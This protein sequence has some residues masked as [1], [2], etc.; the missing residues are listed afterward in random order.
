MNAVIDPENKV[1]SALRAIAGRWRNRPDGE[2]EMVINRLVI[3]P[4]I[5]L[6]LAVAALFDMPGIEPMHFL[7]ISIYVAASIAIAVDLVCRPG[8]SVVRRSLAMALDL[9]TLSYGLHVGD[10]T[11]A[12]LYPIYLWTIFGNGFRF[13]LPYL[14]AATSI[15][16]VG[17]ALVI[18]ATE[19]WYSNLPLAIGLLLGLVVLP[20]Y[21]STLIRKLSAAKRQA[22]EASRAKSQFLASVSHELRTPLNAVIGMSEL[23]RDSDLDREQQDMAGTISGSARSLLSL[24]EGILDFS[25]IEAGR[26][27]IQEIEF[28][29]YAQLSKVRAML[30]PAAAKKGLQLALHVTP[31]IAHWVRGDQKHLEEVLINL[32]GNAVK[33][34]ERGYVL[35][36][37]SVVGMDEGKQRI[38]FEVADTGIGIAPEARSRIFESFT[39]ADETI[40]NR[41]GGTGLGLAISKQL[42]ELQGGRIGVDSEV[43]AGSTFWFELDLFRV[44]TQAELVSTRT[45]LVGIPEHRAAVIRPALA[46]LGVEHLAV[47]D[48]QT[49]RSLRSGFERHA[50]PVVLIDETSRHLAERHA[51]ILDGG[52]SGT[53]LILIRADSATMP[54]REER[55]HFISAVTPPFS[56]QDLEAALRIATAGALSDRPAIRDMASG[57][58]LSILIADDNRTNQ[59]VL[60]KILERG[61]HR[62]HMVDNGE[63]AVDAMMER[64]FDLVFMDVNMPV[65]NGIEATKLYRFAALGRERV[66]IIALTADATPEGR[67]RCLEAGMDECLPKPIEAAELFR[68]IQQFARDEEQPTVMSAPTTELVTDIAAHPKFRADTQSAI[69][70]TTMKELEGL[71]GA[72]FVADLAAQFVEEGTRI[73]AEI[74]SSAANKDVLLFRDRLHALRS[75]AANIG[76]RGLYELCLRLRDVSPSEFTATA[77]SRVSEIEA[78]F[79]RVEK[80][81]RPYSHPDEPGPVRPTAVV[82]RLPRRNPA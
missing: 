19:Y 82:T 49:A 16:V 76:A 23:L 15:S 14:F 31:N 41:F 66:P 61:G 68:V 45:I 17:F 44:E 55:V 78:E 8:V 11:T 75:G 27:P 58:S 56:D 33:F 52:A 64:G 1:R 67:N 25:R 74:R 53:P 43:G 22:E 3:G 42:I 18:P 54:P 6:Y 7:V 62:P 51:D 2:H 28:D 36:T 48:L 79:Q 59:K 50:R 29:L 9:G 77:P 20:V 35:L 12:L 30:A 81:L 38:R 72:E 26:M 63:Q 69:D 24:I 80:S 47:A 21:A 32:V 70:R 37:V 10:G 5:F 73:L 34:T 57:R 46:R 13:G 40:I 39:Q 4:L 60:A 65:M 71:G